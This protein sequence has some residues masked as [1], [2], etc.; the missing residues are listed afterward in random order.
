MNRIKLASKAVL[1]SV[2]CAGSLAF[3]VDSEAKPKP[4]C[5]REGI[6]CTAQYDPVICS[7]GQIYGNACNAYVACATG[8]VPYNDAV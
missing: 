3:T 8:C 7:D 2:L 6:L 5:P 1:A 4:Q